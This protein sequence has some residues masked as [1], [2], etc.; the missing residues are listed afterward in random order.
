MKCKHIKSDGTTC[1][2]FAIKDSDFCFFHSPETKQKHLEAVKRGGE[3]IDSHDYTKLEPIPVE[4]A[5][6]AS[7]LLSDAINRIRIANADG[8]FDL[9]TA[10]SLGFLTSKLLECRKQLLYEEDLLKNAICKDTKIDLA[11]FRQL[12][13][14]YD[15]EYIKN[16]GD[17]IKGAEERYAE[18]KK[19]K[20]KAYLF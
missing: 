18:H 16:V 13:Q 10:N 19:H 20:N 17:F 15:Q 11:T 8:S 14:E 1:K 9:R 2:S 6:S 12:M 4:D 7:Y 5:L 3:A